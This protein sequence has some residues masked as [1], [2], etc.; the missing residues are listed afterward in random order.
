MMTDRAELA[1][2]MVDEGR[3]IDWDSSLVVLEVSRDL[4]EQFKEQKLNE[5]GE[6]DDE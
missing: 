1:I 5:D 6:L 3:L 2:A 4:Y